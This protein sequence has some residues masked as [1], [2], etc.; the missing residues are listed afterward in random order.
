MLSFSWKEEF[1]GNREEAFG[2]VFD[3]WYGTSTCADS[4]RGNLYGA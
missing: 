2:T 3:G 4:G 1:Y